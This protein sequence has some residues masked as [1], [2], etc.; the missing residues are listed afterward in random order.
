MLSLWRTTLILED[1]EDYLK[2]A[3]ERLG[4]QVSPVVDLVKDYA[5]ETAIPSDD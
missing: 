3:Q 2:T 4:E 1:D 5:A